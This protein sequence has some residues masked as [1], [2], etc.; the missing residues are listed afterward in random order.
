MNLH[1]VVLTAII[2]FSVGCA[3]NSS[4]LFNAYFTDDQYVDS[5][6]AVTLSD[7]STAYI[8]CNAQ[9][10]EVSTLGRFPVW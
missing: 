1:R 8:Q 9:G 10:T 2:F 3:L 4:R 7:G 5:L 6:E